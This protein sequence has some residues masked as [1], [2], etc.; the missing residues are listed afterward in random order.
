MTVVGASAGLKWG[1]HQ[2][3]DELG[4][5]PLNRGH[6]GIRS[7]L[8]KVGWAFHPYGDAPDGSGDSGSRVVNA[9]VTP[10]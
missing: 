4:H 2:W 10:L 7:D 6:Q 8:K 3:S 1:E 5:W 9:L